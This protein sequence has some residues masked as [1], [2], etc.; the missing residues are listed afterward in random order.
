MKKMIFIFTV[1]MIST[2]LSFG[3]FSKGTKAIDGEFAILKPSEGDALTML[4][5]QYG[6][7]MT[8]DILVGLQLSYMGM[9]GDSATDFGLFGNYFF[10]D[11]MYVGAG[12]MFPEVG[13]SEAIIQLGML[14]P[15]M[16]SSN[17]HLNPGLQ[18]YTDS[19]VIAAGVS[20]TL[21]F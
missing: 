1:L 9:D 14:S 11:S 10:N 6:Q 16:E 15:F 21:L 8:D 13:D 17:V 12:M 5:L 4:S 18:Y 3:Q 20:L 19:E 2:S 7:F